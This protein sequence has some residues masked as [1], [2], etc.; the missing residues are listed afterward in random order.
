MR[1]PG[2]GSGG[3]VGTL[4]KVAE[5]GVEG[6]MEVGD[7]EFEGDIPGDLG[8]VVVDFG[9]EPDRNLLAADIAWD[10]S[11]YTSRSR[12]RGKLAM[13]ALFHLFLA[14]KCSFIAG[15]KSC[16]VG[17]QLISHYIVSSCSNPD[18]R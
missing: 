12:T 15:A 1:L 18:R 5:W 7:I 10:V 8:D 3:V 11:A 4:S 9:F 2:E 13:K 16:S 17:V 14:V 6:G